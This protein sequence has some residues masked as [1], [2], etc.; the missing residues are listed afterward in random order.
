MLT[1]HYREDRPWGYFERLTSNEPSTVKLLRVDAGKRLSLQRHA[2]RDEYWRVLEG[3]GT[4]EVNG[5][6]RAL[7]PGDSVEVPRGTWHRLS[8]GDAGLM[9]LEIALGAFDESDIERRED[10]FGRA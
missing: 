5:E 10:D 9:L 7:L 1:N 8:G 4:A 2:K 6:S 3:S